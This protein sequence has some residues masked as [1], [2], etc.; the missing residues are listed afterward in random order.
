MRA[1]S[2]LTS[3]ASTTNRMHRPFLSGVI[4]G[5]EP[6]HRPLVHPP[7]RFR[8][9]DQH[10]LTRTKQVLVHHRFITSTV[11]NLMFLPMPLRGL[12]V[13]IPMTRSAGESNDNQIRPLVMVHII[14]KTGEVRTVAMGAISIIN[15]R[16]NLVRCPIRCFVPEFTNKNI[17]LTI[18]VHISN[19]DT[20]TAK[21][22]INTFSRPLHI[23][24]FRFSL[25]IQESR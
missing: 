15:H 14:Y 20:F 13:F 4:S 22:P 7:L 8:S 24:W 1:W 17:C 21:S 12:W 6:C 9:H 10:S 11:P 18:S 3:A 25:R 16:C 23:G 5:T 2:R 19:R